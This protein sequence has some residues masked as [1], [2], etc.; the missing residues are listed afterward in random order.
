MTPKL[1]NF[2]AQDPPLVVEDWGRSEYAVALDRQLDRVRQRREM[3]IPDTFAFTEHSPVYTYGVR[4]SAE[5]HLLWNEAQLRERQI[6]IHKTRRGG[7][8]TFHGPGQI[9]G[10]PFV[11]LEGNRKD[12]HAYL[13][14]LEETVIQSLQSFGLTS[15]RRE[16][17]TGVWVGRRKICAIGVGVKHWITYHGFALN[18]NT[19]LSYFEGIVPCGITDGTVTSLEK[20][21]GK[22]IDTEGVKEILV[23]RFYQLFYSKS[24]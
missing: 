17:M 5:S 2:S 19:D 7:D 11:A 6:Q 13:R 15:G 16:G 21:L 4:K 1:D 14:I 23:S 24:Q 20:E 18:V 3:E 9:V 12:L 10:Y 8:I 22:G